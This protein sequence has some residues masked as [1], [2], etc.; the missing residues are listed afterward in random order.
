MYLRIIFLWVI[1]ASFLSA[2]REEEPKATMLEAAFQQTENPAASVVYPPVKQA[3][4]A[5]ISEV[6]K[7]YPENINF[8]EMV[9]EEV[10][11]QTLGITNISNQP[12]SI[13]RLAIFGAKE[14]FDYEMNCDSQPLLP[15]QSCVV[16]IEAKA[17]YPG[18]YQANLVVTYGEN[19]IAKALLNATVINPPP[20]MIS[21]L[22][23]NALLIRHKRAM[24]IPLLLQDTS[25]ST[26]SISETPGLH[27]DHYPK[28]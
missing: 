12:T 17:L 8:G 23:R 19:S 6:L 15:R 5:I 2:C 25:F 11:R 22:S 21:A 18:N 26:I 4:T 1:C 3:E 24:Q 27:T 28:E 7:F 9:N 10:R 16:T 20:K 13:N 14:A